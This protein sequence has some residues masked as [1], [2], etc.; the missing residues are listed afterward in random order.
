MPFPLTSIPGNH[1]LDLLAKDFTN[2]IVDAASNSIPK[3]TISPYSKPWWNEDLK[4]LRK[5]MLY[6]SHKSKALG[7][8]L[9]KQEFQ[10]TKNT[11]FN[12]IKG[13]KLAH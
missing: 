12:T 4:T 6:Y 13:A 3:S 2:R 8:I 9:Y 5:S 11:Y 1:E 10:N 7:Y